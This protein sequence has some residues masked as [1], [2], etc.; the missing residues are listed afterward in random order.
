MYVQ[1]L[2]HRLFHDIPLRGEIN[3][4]LFQTRRRWLRRSLQNSRNGLFRKVSPSR[5]LWTNVGFQGA[6]EK[7]N[8]NLNL[9][10]L[11]DVDDFEFIFGRRSMK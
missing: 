10:L 11:M 8:F 2:Y 9:Y 1:K 5:R 6:E 7:N 3:Q 4:M